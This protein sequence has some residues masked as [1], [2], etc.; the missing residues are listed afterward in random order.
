MEL[1]FGDGLLR[2][3]LGEYVG[4]IHSDT[5]LKVDNFPENYIATIYSVNLSYHLNA[6]LKD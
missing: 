2:R 3:I 1:K 6:H 4:A 5:V